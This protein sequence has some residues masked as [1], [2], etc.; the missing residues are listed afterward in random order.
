MPDVLLRGDL[1]SRYEAYAI[2][3]NWGLLS[4]NECR[5][6]ENMNRYPLGDVY[7]QPLNMSEAGTK[8]PPVSTPAP[9]GAK[10]LLAA[11]SNAGRRKRKSA[12]NTSTATAAI[13]MPDCLAMQG[14]WV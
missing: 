2:G 12:A 4:A 6:R 7:L 8:P 9:G 5:D 14:R 3:R 1:K 11:R 13:I 10:Y